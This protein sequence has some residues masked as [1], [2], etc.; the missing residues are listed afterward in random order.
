[1]L[2]IILLPFSFLYG[3]INSIR[4][5]L[6]DRRIFKYTQFDI[7]VIG[8]GNLTVGGTGK[9]PMVEY[10]IELLTKKYKVATISRGYGRKTHGFILAGAQETAYTLGD[11]PFQLYQKYGQDVIVAVGEER[12][13]AVPQ[14]LYF[15]PEVQVILLD[16]AFQ[17][18]S[19]KPSFQIL[20]NDFNRPFYKDI[21]MPGGRLR[22]FAKGARRTDVVVVTKCPED[23]SQEKRKTIAKEIHK[24]TGNTKKVFFT[25]IDYKAP[26]N[27]Y[28]KNPTK[29]RN[30]VLVTAIA[31]VAPILNYIQSE[32]TLL[33]HY[34]FSDHHYY[35]QKEVNNILSFAK[36]HKEDVIVITT[37]KDAMK[38]KPFFM[39]EDIPLQVLPIKIK[40]LAEEKVFEQLILEAAAY[41]E[42]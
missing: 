16:D 5:Y 21:P 30:V 1:M 36:N 18:R 19:I 41:K 4:N 38:L 27:V 39:N 37:E 35:T 17:H 20:M 33:K 42:D 12:A 34:K 29:A 28:D 9:T 23:L 15:H 25:S 22:E 32:Y 40:F 10:I 14:T 8:V 24:Y 11:E 2:K 6:Y 31:N 7:P 26:Y 3:L 13:L